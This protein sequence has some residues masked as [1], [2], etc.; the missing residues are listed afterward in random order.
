MAGTPPASGFFENQSWQD[1]RTVL[2]IS[3]GTMSGA[4]MMANCLSQRGGV[5]CVTRED[6][7]AVVNGYGGLATRIAEQIRSADHAYEQF[8]DIR[9]PYLILMR[10]A[11]LEYARKGGLAYF[12]YSGHLLVPKI[13]HFVRIRLI[14]PLDVR[15]ARTRRS[16]GCDTPEAKEYLRNLDAERARWA[17]MM[18]GVDIREPAGYDVCINLERLS[19]H[20]ACDLLVKVREQTDFQPTPESLAHV[21]NE[22]LATQVLAALATDPETL[23]VEVGATATDGSVRLVGPYV[24]GDPL[25]AMLAAA[26]SVPG[27]R[28]VEYEPG[29]A[30]AFGHA[31]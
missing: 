31:S 5:R 15:L 11:L 14:A 4:T 9:R 26:R 21:E 16:L 23:S 10:R 6:L 20:G 2:L 30:P 8:S 22:Y 19:L 28:E 3:R 7:L 12:G 24:P 18:Y 29:Y 1:A 27:V 25:R 13:A 17:R